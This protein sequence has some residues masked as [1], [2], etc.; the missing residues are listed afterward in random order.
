MEFLI[1]HI[2]MVSGKLNVGTFPISVECL[3]CICSAGLQLWVTRG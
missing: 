2:S 3:F 1:S